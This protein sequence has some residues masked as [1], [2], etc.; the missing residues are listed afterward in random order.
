[1]DKIEK[2]RNELERRIALYSG[3]SN[4]TVHPTRIDED[5]QLLS[6]L[7]TLSEE[8]DKSLEEAADRYASSVKGDYAWSD[9]PDHFNFGDLTDAFVAGAEWKDK[10]VNRDE[11]FHDG[12]KYEYDQLMKEAV[13]GEIVDSG[14]DDGTAILKAIV[15]DRGYDSG[16][17]VKLIVIKED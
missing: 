3:W 16:D 12:M 8:P 7:D 11:I 6:F 9:G 15:P 14:F 4:E 1:M 17:K 2:I 10:Q 13:E 5:K